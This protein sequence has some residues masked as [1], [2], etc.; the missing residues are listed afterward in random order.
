MRRRFL[1]ALAAG[2]PVL[3]AALRAE[4]HAFLA[5]ASPPVGSTGPAPSTVTITFTEAVEP[6]FST[7]TVS[8]ARGERVDSGEVSTA[9]TDG[10]KLRVG[11]KPLGAGTYTV[12]WK[13]T[14]V[15]TH[16]TEGTFTFTVSP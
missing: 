14:S 3:G 6:A 5:S 15:D 12:V 13:I 1:L 2:A 11:L 9:S 8:N 10:R 16:K 4:A 7:I